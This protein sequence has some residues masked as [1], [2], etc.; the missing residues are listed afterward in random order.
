MQFH[1]SKERTFLTGN[2]NL[3]QVHYPTVSTLSQFSSMDVSLTIHLQSRSTI[4]LF[5]AP[6]GKLNNL[7]LKQSGFNNH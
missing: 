6:F 2:K 4:A 5:L 3:E 7:Q 1:Q